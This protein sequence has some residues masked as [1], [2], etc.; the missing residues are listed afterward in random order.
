MVADLADFS[1]QRGQDL[2]EGV[3]KEGDSEGIKKAW[4]CG[5]FFFWR[6]EVG[7]DHGERVEQDRHDESSDKEDHLVL[8]DRPRR[9]REGEEVSCIV[10]VEIKQRDIR[11]EEKR[12]QPSGE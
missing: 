8:L 7:D 5:L 2:P 10:K 3:P 12:S 9:E 1:Q 11:D 4:P 6:G